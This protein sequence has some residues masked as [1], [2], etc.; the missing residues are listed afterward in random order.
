MGIGMSE[1]IEPLL[2]KS[3]PVCKSGT[4][5]YEPNPILKPPDVKF[6]LHVAWCDDCDVNLSVF[7]TDDGFKVEYEKEE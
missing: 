6:P 3:C 1:A 4:V 2:P 5:E 7:M